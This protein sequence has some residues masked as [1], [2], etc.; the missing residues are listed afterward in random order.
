MDLS[1]TA[2]DNVFRDEVRQFLAD[3]FDDDL[4]KKMA[5]NRNSY[6]PKEDHVRWQ[7]A[8]AKKG[9]LTPD[10]PVEYGGPGWNTTQKYIFQTEI[11]F[12]QLHL[13]H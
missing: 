11:K 13:H 12:Q 9:W 2:Q 4:K 6:L 3:E 8:L 10:W 7:K 5:E 1:F